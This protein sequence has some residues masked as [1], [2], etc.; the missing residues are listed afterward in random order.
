[1]IRFV[2]ADDLARI[3]SI[4]TDMFTDRALQFRD[5]L[6]WDVPVDANGCERDAYD[7]VNPMYVIATTP[8]GRHAGSMRILPT[9][10]RTMVA[11]HFSHLADGVQIA[12]PLVWET[13]RYCISPRLTRAEDALKVSGA[14]LLAGCELGLRFGLT[15]SVGVFEARMLAIYRRIGWAPEVLGRDGPDRRDACLG[16][17]D[18]TEKAMAAIAARTGHRPEDAA[19]WFDASF[20]A[21][22]MTDFA[23]VA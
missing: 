12:S 14:L 2:Y 16:L 11:D 8:T 7:S 17:W 5:R 10:G 21:T 6:G 19:H 20:P 22:S 13:T 15:P 9:C 1:M 4:A 3:P 18:I 23:A